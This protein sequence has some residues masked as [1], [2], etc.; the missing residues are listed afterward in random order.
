MT[1]EDDR[2]NRGATVYCLDAAEWAQERTRTLEPDCDCDCNSQPKV[3]PAPK[4][5]D[6][7]SGAQNVAVSGLANDSVTVVGLGL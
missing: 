1:R 5:Q 4:I 3:C 7:L 6:S 2:A